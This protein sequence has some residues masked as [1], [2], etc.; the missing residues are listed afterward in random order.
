MSQSDRLVQQALQLKTLHA[1]ADDI[2]HK[3]QKIAQEFETL[4]ADTWA[5]QLHETHLSLSDYLTAVKMVIDDSFD[6]EVWVRAEIRAINSKGGHYYFELAEKDE[7][8]QITASCRAT[9]WRFKANTLLSKFSVATGQT[10][11]A[12]ISVLIKCSANFHAQYG[13]SLTISDIDPHY[14]LGELAAAYMLMKKRLADE[15]LLTLNQQLPTPFDIQHV[16]VI[17]PERA[18][19]LGDFR[20][21]ADRLMASGACHFYYHHATFQGNHAPQEIRLALTKSLKAFDQSIGGLPDLVVIIRGGGAVGD[22]AYLNDYELAALIAECPVPVWVGIGHERDMVILDEVAHTSFD[23]PSKVIHG[24]E[25][26]LIHLVQQANRHMQQITQFA[27]HQLQSHQHQSERLIQRIHTNATRQIELAKKD[28]AYL[29]KHLQQL[30]LQHCKQEKAK[31][32]HVIYHTQTLSTKKLNKA[33]QDAHQQFY[34]HQAL[35][36]RLSTLKTHCQHLQGLILVQNPARVLTK[37]YALIFDNNEQLISRSQQLVANQS[38]R[39]QLQDGNAYATIN[40]I[41]QVKEYHDNT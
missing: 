40:T 41:T 32:N 17:S 5:E 33:R 29:N 12:G 26:H 10:L 15:G 7:Q 39:I 36:G 3:H 19:G 2:E 34:R 4:Q 35:F 37:G 22:L 30:S 24:I 20:Q 28:S 18:A 11:Q 1:N 25:T 38:V 13:F 31:L 6:H 21:E 9:L 27:K 8:G 16:I 14:T 23:T